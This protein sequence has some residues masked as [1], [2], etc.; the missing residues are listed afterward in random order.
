MDARMKIALRFNTLLLLVS[1]YFIHSAEQLLKRAHAA[2]T[3]HAF[4][5]CVSSAAVCTQSR[6]RLITAPFVTV[7]FLFN[8]LSLGDAG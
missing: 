2:Y 5:V 8:F 7:H 4:K 6:E 1:Q 3:I